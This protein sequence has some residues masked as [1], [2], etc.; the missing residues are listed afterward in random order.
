MDEEEAR[1]LVASRGWHHRFEIYPG[2]ITPGR[3]D[4]QF[5]LDKLVLPGDLRGARII[6]IGTANGFFARALHQRGAEVH[7]VDY[8][9]KAAIG[10]EI[11]ERLYG[12]PIAFTHANIYDLPALDLGQF[13]YVLCL[14]VIYHLPDIA[15]AMQ[16]LHRLTRP[17][18]AAFVESY[19]EDFGVEAPLARYIPGAS[20]ASDPTNFWAPNIACV[21]AMMEDVGFATTELDRWG[22][23]CLVRGDAGAQSKKYAIAYK[24]RTAEDT[25]R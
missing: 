22:D 14:G 17:G 7:A 18:G 15:C 12:Q 5:M 25:P 24:A 11:M 8:R 10:F 13:D 16:V 20:L 4:P 21:C 19:V 3:Y 2:I 23:R 1:A 9:S 6:D